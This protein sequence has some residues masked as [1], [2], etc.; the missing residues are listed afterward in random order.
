MLNLFS[1]VLLLF[2]TSTFAQMTLPSVFPDMRSVNPAV[3]PLR[4]LGQLK[5]GANQENFDKKQEVK[6][7]N[8]SPF[9][10]TDQSDISLTNFNFF[11]GGKG[12]GATSELYVDSTTG[13]KETTITDESQSVSKFTTDVSSTYVSYAFGGGGG[14][15]T[16]WGIGTHYVGYNSKYEFNFDLNGS[17]NSSSFETTTT[18]YGIRPGIIFGSPNLSFGLYY[19][20]DNLKSEVKSSE[21]GAKAG[22]PKAM[23][24]VGFGIGTGGPKGIL[25]I[26][27]ETSLIAPEKDPQTNKEPPRAMKLSLLAERRFSRITLGYKG[28]LYQGNYMDLDKIIQNQLIYI[29]SADTARIEHTLNLSFGG[30]KGFSFGVSGGASNIKTKEKSSIYAASDKHDTTIKSTSFGARIGY[31]Y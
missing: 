29:N 22:A 30:D 18:L 13:K 4:K 19:E 12:G 20:Y 14:S 9:V 10:F 27:A 31:V 26:A 16:R 6:T 2:S 17:N 24:M 21:P 3:I 8:N 1:L 7:I 11:R 15:G 5:L 23:Q 25:E 28:S